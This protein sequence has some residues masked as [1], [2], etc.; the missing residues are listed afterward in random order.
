M[1]EWKLHDEYSTVMHKDIMHDEH[2]YHQI[3]KVLSNI[4]TRVSK[5]SFFCFSF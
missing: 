5:N 3:R 4:K 1:K 2:E